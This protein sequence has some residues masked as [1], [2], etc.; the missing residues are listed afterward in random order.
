[1][2]V[3]LIFDSS[4]LVW[5][6]VFKKVGEA[7]SN[8]WRTEEIYKQTRRKTNEVSVTLPYGENLLNDAE[9]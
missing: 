6:K 2:I 4:Y 3:I 8:A 1:M 9:F 7:T 5:V